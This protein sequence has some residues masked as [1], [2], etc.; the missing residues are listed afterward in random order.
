MLK[1]I[2]ISSLLILSSSLYATYTYEA[3]QDLIDL[4]SQSGTTN[5]A[6]SDDGVS[7]AFNIGFTFDFYG[8]AFT[9]A[10]MATNGC[11]HFKTSGAYCNDYTPDPLTGQHTYTLYPFWTDLIRD[12]GS[13]VLAKS[14]SDKTVFG[15]YNLREYNRNG[16][17]NSIEVILWTNDTF[18]FRYGALDIINHDVLIGE[19][20]AGTSEIYQYLFHDECSTGTTNV[21]GTCTSTNWNNSSSNTLLEN[22]GSLYGLGSGNAIDCSNVLNNSSCVGY[23]AAYLTQQCNLDSLYNTSCPLYWDA[24]DDLQCDL[25]SQYAP[26]CAGYTQE[27]SVAYYVEEDYGY[28]QED[29]WYDE[30]YEEWLDPNDPCYENR[31]EGFTDAD[32]YAIDV[33]EFGQE[34]VD[35]WFGTDVQFSNDGFV[36]WDT[37]ILT[38]YDDVDILMDTWDIEQEQYHPQEELLLEEFTFQETFLVE[39]YSEPETFIEFETIGELDEWLEEEM[40]EVRE[41]AESDEELEE[42]FEEEAVE[43]IYEDLEEEWVAETEEEIS[44]EELLQEDEEVFV[45]IEREEREGSS[46]TRERALNVVANTIRTAR[47]S[48]SGTSSSNAIHTT[49]NSTHSTGNTIV[50]SNSSNSSGGGISTTNSPSRSDQFASATVQT[51]TVLSLNNDSTVENVSVSITPMPTLDDS[52]QIVMA[53]VQVQDMQGQIDTAISGVMTTSE[54]DQVADKIIAQNIEAQQEEAEVE[55]QRTG[56][57]AD[58]STLVAYLGYVAGFDA[59]RNA[60]L[61]PQSTW[62]EPKVIYTS[63]LGDNVQAFYGLAGTSISRLSEMQNLQ[64]NL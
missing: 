62:Y 9:Q 17:D 18:D 34:T 45:S 2:I 26:F 29:M 37:T 25:D 50:S 59:Y 3:N 23:A 55:Q 28:T 14:F 40:D 11:L 38:S 30:E 53:D 13:K 4:T 19:I 16:S 27:D 44:N 20:G 57:Y 12:N 58:S 7:S 43:E 24:Y 46:M 5:L 31:C 60:Q 47:N 6:A 35:E 15:W 64:P 63:S 41:L 42:I 48:V 8:Q 10:R 39:D 61:P 52:P 21:T 56:E 1:N 32:W 33:E 22:G 49:G 51:N 54:A 36:E